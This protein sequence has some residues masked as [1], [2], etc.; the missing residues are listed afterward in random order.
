[1]VTQTLAMFLTI[2]ITAT[3]V[4][5]VETLARRTL[6]FSQQDMVMQ[7]FFYH[8]NAPIA[9][10][11]RV[12]RYLRY[13]HVDRKFMS[14]DELVQDLPP[15]LRAD[16]CLVIRERHLMRNAFFAGLTENALRH[17]CMKATDN[18]YLE[19]DT[20]VEKGSLADHAL[21]LTQGS[22]VVLLPGQ[23]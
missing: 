11:L 13:K 10:R 8:H 4:S 20:V 23:R 16:I 1:M 15:S 6:A 22:A 18:F 19:G 9:L 2:F 3:M 5:L 14:A 7:D 12:T 17:I 21:F